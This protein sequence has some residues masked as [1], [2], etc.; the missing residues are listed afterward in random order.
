MTLITIYRRQ[1]PTA[2]LY[3][4]VCNT[5]LQ[6][7]GTQFIQMTDV[8]NYASADYDYAT[9]M[10]R[11]LAAMHTVIALD[12]TITVTILAIASTVYVELENSDTVWRTHPFWQSPM[13]V[14]EINLQWQVI[15]NVTTL[16]TQQ[17][18]TFQT[19]LQ[20]PRTSV[21]MK[22]STLCENTAMSFGIS[23]LYLVFKCSVN[24]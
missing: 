23:S 2:N 11:L 24:I 22:H 3:K 16:D 4:T 20:A 9:F 12:F 8:W 1:R 6:Y 10:K 18:F 14:M 5:T 17:R 13:A 15:F 21:I 19:L 7:S